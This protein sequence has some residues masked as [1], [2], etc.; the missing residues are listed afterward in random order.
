MTQHGPP[1]GHLASDRQSALPVDHTPT[2]REMIATRSALKR[3]VE[4]LAGS[5]GYAVLPHWRLRQ[6]DLAEHLK[7]LFTALQVDCVLDVGA[8]RG[9]YRDFLRAQ[10]GY[11]GAIV[12]F[13]PVAENVRLLTDRAAAD[14][15][16]TIMALALGGEDGIAEINVTAATE[17][18]SFFGPT[19][20]ALPGIADHNVVRRTETVQVKRLD[21]IFEKAIADHGARS[22]F[23]KMDTQGSDMDVLQGARR[24]LE[25][26][27]GLQ[28]EVSVLPLYD[29]IPNYLES[30]AYMQELGFHL[31]GMFPVNRDRLLR[32]VEFDCVMRRLDRE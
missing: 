1:D 26:I 23:L 28:S 14:R 18:S 13:E 20:A 12:S 11:T 27:R 10:I 21:S 25:R 32:V 2:S 5:M 19:K 3:M 17:F 30:I 8:N 29:G 22:V 15:R 4:R 7:G 31:T 9:Q 16:W 24:S 6:Y